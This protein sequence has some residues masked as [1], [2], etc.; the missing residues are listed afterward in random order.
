MWTFLILIVVFTAWTIIE[1]INAPTLTE[2][3]D[4][5]IEKLKK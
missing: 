4:E 2:D 3:E 5:F 1:V